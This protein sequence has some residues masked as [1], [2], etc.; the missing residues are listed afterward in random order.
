VEDA[1]G[2][3]NQPLCDV[4]HLKQQKN[5]MHFQIAKRM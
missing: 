4:D 2:M 1:D 3:G 5:T